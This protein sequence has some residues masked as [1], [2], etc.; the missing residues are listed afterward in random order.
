M[1]FINAG[2]VFNIQNSILYSHKN[3]GVAD[4]NIPVKLSFIS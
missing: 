4:I 1:N 3:N 2:C